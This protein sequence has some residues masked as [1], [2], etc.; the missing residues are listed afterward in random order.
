M[1]NSKNVYKIIFCVVILIAFFLFFLVQDNQAK[2]Q[3]QAD[4]IFAEVQSVFFDYPELPERYKYA[5]VYYNN[6]IDEYML[7]ING[8]Q[9]I[10]ALRDILQKPVYYFGDYI[11]TPDLDEKFGEADSSVKSVQEIVAAAVKELLGAQD[12][13][14]SYRPA[15]GLNL[16]MWVYPDE[17]YIQCIREAAPENME[18]MVYDRDDHGQYIRWNIITP[19]ENVMLYLF[20]R[21]GIQELRENKSAYVRGWGEIPDG[22]YSVLF[23]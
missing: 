23:E 7:I 13:T 14:Y 22:I 15:R 18:V 10:S 16:P 12:I 8:E 17:Q 4:A 19:D 21:T 1:K 9:K 5:E 2:E 6:G 3:Q 20:A 11:W